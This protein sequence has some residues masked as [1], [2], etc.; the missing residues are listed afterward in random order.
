MQTQ[1]PISEKQ[2]RN[3]ARTLRVRPGIGT[4]P[5]S[6]GGDNLPPWQCERAAILQRACE[7]VKSRVGRGAG[8][9][10]SVRVVAR[11][12]NG[13]RFKTDPK[14]TLKLSRNTLL[15][16]YYAWH[17]GGET[18]GVFRLKFS[19][20]HSLFTNLVI[21]RFADFLVAHPQRTFE[22]AWNMFSARRSNFK[23]RWRP[24]KRAVREAITKGPEIRLRVLAAST[25]PN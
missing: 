5:A 13:K 20:R 8:L 1:N 3:R 4:P 24:V 11:G 12:N 15:R 10:R 25:L 16:L 2:T 22:S 6:A 23:G 7:R 17:K 14:R 19:Q 9:L 18:A 21:L